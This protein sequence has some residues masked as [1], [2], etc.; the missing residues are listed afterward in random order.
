MERQFPSRSA[1]EMRSDLLASENAFKRQPIVLFKTIHGHCAFPL[2]QFNC[3]WMN[4]IERKLWK[5][6]SK[7]LRLKKSKFPDWT[8]LNGHSTPERIVIDFDWKH[9]HKHK[10]HNKAPPYTSSEHPAPVNLALWCHYSGISHHQFNGR[11]FAYATAARKGM[12]LLDDAAQR[13]VDWLWRWRW[14]VASATHLQLKCR[15]C[16][17]SNANREN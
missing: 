7:S 16:A 13:L 5:E 2:W 6:K 10:S 3:I 9:I 15:G 8:H 14:C 4:R 1:T 12:E 17:W 11:G